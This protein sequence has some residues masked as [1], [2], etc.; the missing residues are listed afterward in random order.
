MRLEDKII[1]RFAFVVLKLSDIALADIRLEIIYGDS[2][3]RMKCDTL[4]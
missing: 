4:K 3:I 1:R 2:K